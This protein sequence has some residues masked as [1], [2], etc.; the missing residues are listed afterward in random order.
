MRE[1]VDLE[2]DQLFLAS[3]LAVVARESARPL[4]RTEAI[5][6][7]PREVPRLQPLRPPSPQPR[8]AHALAAHAA[9][10][11]VGRCAFQHV[12]QR[13]GADR[14]R[15]RRARAPSRHLLEATRPTSR[16]SLRRVRRP[17]GRR[18]AC[19]GT[20]CATR[21]RRAARRRSRRARAARAAARGCARRSCRTRCRGRRGSRRAR[22]PAAIAASTR[23]RRYAPTSRTT[24]AYAG[25]LLHRARRALH[26]HRN[27]AGFALGDDRAAC[28]RRRAARHVVHD[29]RTGFQRGGRDRGLRRV[30]ADGTP[31]RRATSARTTGRTRRSLFVGVDRFRAGPGRLTAD[32]E[33]RG[34]RREPALVRARSPR[35]ARGSV[36]RRRRSP[37]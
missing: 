5:L 22:T 16:A 12:E 3:H 31:R 9:T 33:H 8:G 23:P 7:H 6:D 10:T 34:T 20:T 17:A 25:S 35:R 21:R 27:E 11:P 13:G 32:V 28:D 37:A 30:D 24:S 19:R 15:R 1:L 29:R 36:R 2:P 14:T 18:A 26:V 4:P